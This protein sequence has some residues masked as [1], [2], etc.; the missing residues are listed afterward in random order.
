MDQITLRIP[1]VTDAHFIRAVID[2]A[3]PRAASQIRFSLFTSQSS[4]RDAS[5]AE[6][7]DSNSLLG[8]VVALQGMLCR[9]IYVDFE[10][11]GTAALSRHSDPNTVG[12]SGFR[13]EVIAMQLHAKL[14]RSLAAFKPGAPHAAALGEDLQ[15]YYVA[16]EATLSRLE[17]SIALL[18]KSA[19]NDL[20]K[21]EEFFRQKEIALQAKLDAGL[22]DIEAK[23]V[24]EQQDLEKTKA[25]LAE[26]V[27]AVDDSAAKYARRA[28]QER[29]RGEI[30]KRQSISELTP[31]TRRMRWPVMVALA[32]LAGLLG[33]GFAVYTKELIGEL[34][35]AT[36][37][38]PTILVSL[39]VRQI[40]LG[41][42]VGATVWYFIHWQNQWFQ[43]HADEEFRIKRLELDLDR[44][45]W[46]VELA[47]E[48]AKETGAKDLPPA[49]MSELT[50]NLF[51]E[52]DGLKA[53][54][55]ED[56]S[57]LATLLGA[58]TSAEVM[59]GGNRFTLNRKAAEKLKAALT[60][61]AK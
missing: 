3:A 49:L 56:V 53:K 48:W 26:R 36:P 38:D 29:L 58:A 40:F 41:I 59:V 51:T 45:S 37:P 7:D 22:K 12:V 24:A 32:A 55:S 21:R 10:G 61:Q 11:G 4:G 23:R 25:D 54:G 28:L 57:A 19:Q 16:R 42:G 2:E 8:K 46:V 31:G 39:F 50:K 34:A 17:D 6:L 9:E 60:P 18:L 20:E 35:K 5:P 33:Y 1:H 14:G 30:K 27:K 13:D 47:M 52:P 44:A 43:R 15:K